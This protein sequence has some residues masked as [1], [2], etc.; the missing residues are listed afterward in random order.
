MAE[1]VLALGSNLGERIGNLREALVALGARGVTVDRVSSVWE[2][3]PVPA[4]QPM[5]LN[6]VVAGKTR[7]EPAELLELLKTIE[8]ELGRTPGRRWGPRPI[9]LD[10][11]FYDALEMDSETLT[12]PHP[13]IAGRAFVLAPLAEVIAGPLPVL[14]RTASELL[15]AVGTDG[16][17][18][19]GLVLM[20][21]PSAVPG[22]RETP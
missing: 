12:I 6:A 20:A 10:I 14:G 17:S 13:R 18:R 8:R 9:D 16:V 4:D 2:T 15:N 21:G 1:V 7:M 19:T 3:A 11:L 5:Y 22:A